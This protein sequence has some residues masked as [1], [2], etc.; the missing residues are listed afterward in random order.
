MSTGILE[1]LRQTKPWVTMMGVLCFIAAGLMTFGAVVLVGT[2]LFSGS[3]DRVMGIGMG[4]V[5]LLLGLMY[6]IPG[7][8][9]IRYS[10]RIK[11]LLTAPSTVG[12]EEAL[13]A[14]KSFWKCVGVMILAMIVLYMLMAF[15]AI[16]FSLL[17]NPN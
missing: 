11:A 8:Y 13:I 1:A 6:V 14:Q 4:V 5:Y 3:S 10:R 15:G 12:L 2:M 7:F 16:G 9:L 17:V